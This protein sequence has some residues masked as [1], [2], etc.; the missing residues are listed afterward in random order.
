MDPVGRIHQLCLPALL[1]PLWA[2]AEIKEQGKQTEGN[3]AERSF[4]LLCF[5]ILPSSPP[6]LTFT[7]FTYRKIKLCAGGKQSER[8]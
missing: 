3:G 2:A 8:M 1:T 4:A 6:F 7:S 5:A